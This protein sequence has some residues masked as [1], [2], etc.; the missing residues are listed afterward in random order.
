[1]LTGFSLSEEDRLKLLDL[2]RADPVIRTQYLTD[3]DLNNIVNGFVAYQYVEGGCIY[4]RGD[5]PDSIYY[6]FRGIV[7]L[8]DTNNPN[9]NTSGT[10]LQAGEIFGEKDFFAGSPRARM[11]VVSSA[12]CVVLRLDGLKYNKITET[13]TMLKMKVLSK[14][15]W[16]ETDIN[17]L[18]QYIAVET[19]VDGEIIVKKGS[20]PE[21]HCYVV[22]TGFVKCLN[23]SNSVSLSDKGNSPREK[24]AQP[25]FTSENKS[26][27][28]GPNEGFGDENVED[29]VPY[30]HT[31]VAVGRANVVK[32]DR[33]GM[34]NCLNFL[35]R[36]RDP[37]VG[38]RLRSASMVSQE[39][40]VI[41]IE[42]FDSA[43]SAASANWLK[44]ARAPTEKDK[45]RARKLARKH[46]RERGGDYE[47]DKSI[48][49]FFDCL[50]R[51]VA[52]GSDLGY[53][54]MSNMHMDLIKKH[55]EEDVSDDDT[56]DEGGCTEER[57]C[58]GISRPMGISRNNNPMNK[59]AERLC[60]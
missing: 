12:T 38:L 4:K 43:D 28:L 10:L 57:L 29:D 31:Y 58:G 30:A 39:S 11:S 56:D 54:L 33:G 51:P 13:T 17:D 49:S 8:H 26:E 9:A 50:G 23:R 41:S 7:K 47:T 5:K 45:K 44:R 27:L 32:M 20:M 25:S 1:M 53:N 55:P 2:I 40:S 6:I 18:K 15:L 60:I 19:F 52:A 14:Q 34:E 16:T 35:R 24:K 22:V 42:R 3:N 59:S 48:L 36:E 46:F 21:G 37:S